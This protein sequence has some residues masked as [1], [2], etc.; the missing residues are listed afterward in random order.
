M[1]YRNV[2]LIPGG[3]EE[4]YQ[5]LEMIADDAGQQSMADNEA[6]ADSVYETISYATQPAAE[7]PPENNDTNDAECETN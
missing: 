5:N 1:A 7:M 4:D 6:T 3:G 2:D